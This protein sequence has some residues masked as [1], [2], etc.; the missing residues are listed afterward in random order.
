[1]DL[2]KKIFPLSF[3][4][5]KDVKDLIVGIILYVIGGAIGGV[6][7]AI[8]SIIPIIGWIFGALGGLIELYVVVGIVLQLLVFFKIIK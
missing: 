1:M 4:Y 2:L 8:V 5:V 6:A 3:K 7:L